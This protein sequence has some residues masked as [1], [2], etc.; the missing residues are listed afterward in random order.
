MRKDKVQRANDSKKHRL[1][2][3]KCLALC[4]M[5]VLSDLKEVTGFLV[6]L[7]RGHMRTIPKGDIS[8]GKV[9]T[10]HSS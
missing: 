3:F 4:V 10:I 6:V 1:L 9:A 2:L 8:S 5:D 7:V